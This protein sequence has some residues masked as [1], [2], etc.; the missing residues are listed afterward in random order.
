[1]SEKT[2]FSKILDGEIPSD[3]LYQDEH[4]FCIRDINPQA[5][6]HVLV[7]PK[8]P[9]ARLVDAQSDDEV[10][11]GRLM[12]AV[13]KIAKQ[14]GVGDAFRVCINNGAAAGQTVFHLHVHILAGKTF[15]ENSLSMH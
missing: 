12:L 15:N 4:C 1:M 2:L 9:I 8:K 14:L 10:L 7:I 11:L 6:T 5:P 13:G 3:I